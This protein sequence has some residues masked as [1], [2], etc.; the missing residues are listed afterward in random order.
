MDKEMA[1]QPHSRF[2]LD[3]WAPAR[4][5]RGILED[6]PAL[7]GRGQTPRPRW[8]A[9]VLRRNGLGVGPRPS[10]E[11][12]RGESVVVAERRAALEPVAL[13]GKSD[14]L[15]PIVHLELLDNVVDVILHRVERKRKPLGDLLVAQPAC[16]KLKDLKFA[17]REAH[18]GRMVNPLGTTSAEMRELRKHRLNDLRRAEQLAIPDACD[19][20]LQFAHRGLLQHAPL[21]TGGDTLQKVLIRFAARKKDDL[22]TLQTAMEF[23]CQM[24]SQLVRQSQREK[25]YVGLLCFERGRK[26]RGAWVGTQRLKRRVIRQDRDQTLSKQST[27]MNDHQANWRTHDAGPKE[28]MPSRDKPS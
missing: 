18:F 5:A 1:T 22:H 9:A 23:A 14:C 17:R 16:D 12:P 20:S 11:A 3:T 2:G 15:V 27:R 24:E 6:G 4:G 25:D 26:P 8:K 19:D 7:S 10:P 13:A 21:S 28:L